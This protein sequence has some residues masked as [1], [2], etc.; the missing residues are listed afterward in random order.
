MHYGYYNFYTNP[1]FNYVNVYGILAA[2]IISAVILGIVL[3]CTFLKKSNEGKF[4]GL[5]EI[6]Y[7]ALT[8]NRFYAEKIIKFL[9]VIA[10]CVITVAGLTCIVLGAF[11]AGLCLIVIGN[12]ILRVA[13]ELVLMFVMICKKTVSID[14]RLSG[15]E[16]FYGEE[17]GDEAYDY[18]AQ[19]ECD[20]DCAC[21]DCAEDDCTGWE[22]ADGESEDVKNGE[23]D[24][25]NYS[26]N[27]NENQ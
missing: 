8:F 3:S 17:Y 5:K 9:Y 16:A 21:A 2:A 6:I 14:K 4:V 7:N 22:C 20:G 12:I 1:I 25:T 27:E 18:E 26:A 23:I 19:C 13:V 10:A 24:N 15:I 11:L